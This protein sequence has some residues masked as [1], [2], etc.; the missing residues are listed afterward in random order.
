MEFV[1]L[2]YY[3]FIDRKSVLLHADHVTTETGTGCVHTAPAH[4]MDDYLICKKN[5]IDTIHS[6]NNKAFFKDELDFIAGLPAMKADPLIVEKLQE[7]NA[8]I[9][10]EAVSYTHLTLPTTP[11]V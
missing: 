1:T 4:G 7:H 6:L 10:I 8:L 9:N 3:P 11:Y 2:I 5:N